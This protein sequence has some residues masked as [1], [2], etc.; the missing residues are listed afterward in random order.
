MIDGERMRMVS[1]AEGRALMGFPAG[2]QLPANEAQAWGL[3]GNAVA[4]PQARD[5]ISALR[6]AA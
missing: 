2:Y 1:A 3:L 6:A 5:L 4:P